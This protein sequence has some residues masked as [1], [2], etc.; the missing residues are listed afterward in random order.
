MKAPD[1]SST[2]LFSGE[3]FKEEGKS[4]Q[5]DLKQRCDKEKKSPIYEPTKF[6]KFCSPHG[7]ADCFN[8]VLACMTSSHH[9]ED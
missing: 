1:K 6:L 4:L 9:S 7:A 3:K 8:F 5:K 2:F